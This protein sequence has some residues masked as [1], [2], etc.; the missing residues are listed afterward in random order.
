MIVFGGAIRP[1]LNPLCAIA[2]VEGVQVERIERQHVSM[3]V[4]H[5]ATGWF[6]IL[7]RF[8][9]HAFTGLD[10]EKDSKHIAWF[11]RKYIP[12]PLHGWSCIPC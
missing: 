9:P 5:T 4:A 7:V 2:G 3:P 1:S 11:K 8:L 12:P 10:A 6:G